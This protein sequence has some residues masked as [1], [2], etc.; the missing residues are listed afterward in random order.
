MNFMNFMNKIVRGT[1]SMNF[2]SASLHHKVVKCMREHIS[3]NSGTN[4]TVLHHLS[5]VVGD[6]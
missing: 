2:S 4:L 3:K 6:I 5:N 1:G